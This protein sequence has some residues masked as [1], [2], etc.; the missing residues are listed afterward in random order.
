MER[1][2]AKTILRDLPQIVPIQ[3]ADHPGHHEPGTGEI[4]FLNPFRFIDEAG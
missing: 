2:L 3:T 1:N 4:N